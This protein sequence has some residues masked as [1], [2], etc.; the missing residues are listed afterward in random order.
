MELLDRIIS[1]M[2]GKMPLTFEHN[3]T[4][5]A[6]L[7]VNFKYLYETGNLWWSKSLGREECSR[8]MF[9]KQYFDETATKFPT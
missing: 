4:L 5:T 6:R 3:E 9:L 1:E 2:P 7:V 8:R